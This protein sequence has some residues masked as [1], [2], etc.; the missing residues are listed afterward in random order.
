MNSSPDNLAES[1][2]KLEIFPWHTNLLSQLADLKKQNRI[3]HAILI[4][5]KSSSDAESFMT[6]LATLLLCDNNSDYKICGQCKSC[7]AMQSASYSNFKLITILY[8]E[9]KKKVNKNINIEQIRKVIYDINL[10]PNFDNYNIVAIY[11]AEKM[12][13]EAANSLLKTLEEPGKQA[14]IILHTNNKGLLPVTIRSRCQIWNLDNPDDQTALEWLKQQGLSETEANHHLQL[15]MGDPLLAKQ[16][17][18]D[19]YSE[20]AET[21]KISFTAFLKGRSEVTALA[22]ELT[23]YQPNVIRRLI[24]RVVTAYCYRFCGLDSEGNAQATINR[25]KAMSMF[26]LYSVAFK[27]LAV[28]DNNLDL[29]LQLED[30]LISIKQILKTQ[31]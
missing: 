27:R 13:R 7:R 29:H 28:E 2:K 15:S 25:S 9:K 24:D 30:V 8:D 12:G 14:V 22:S 4:D 11:P 31:D 20:I 23:K 5:S 19:N 1:S 26:E 6:Y 17:F 16:M 10:S 18:G 3:P 21:F